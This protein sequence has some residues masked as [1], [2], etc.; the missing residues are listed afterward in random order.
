MAD[1]R[2][3]VEIKPYQGRRRH[4]R[5]G[6]ASK[7][8]I[9]WVLLLVLILALSHWL[10]R[11]PVS[12]VDSEVPESAE[13]P[14]ASAVGSAGKG[15]IGEGVDEGD[16]DQCH[17]LLERF[18]VAESSADRL[19]LVLPTEALAE[20]MERFY[21]DNEALRVEVKTLELTAST[22]LD[23]PEG[24]TLLTR[25][26]SGD[27]ATFDAAFRRAGGQWR[28]DWEHFVRYSEMSWA[29]FHSGSGP[30]R[31]VFRLLARQR[32][33]SSEDPDNSI[34]VVLSGPVRRQLQMAGYSASVVGIPLSE[35]DGQLL[36][37]A[38]EMAEAG[39]PPFGARYRNL[40]P[41]GMIR[42]RVEVGRE[43]EDGITRCRILRVL[44]CHW[45]SSTASLVE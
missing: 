8:V 24:M 45:L 7:L 29:R 10:M 28:L 36:Q 20:K 23:L 30:D 42:V 31:A 26:E 5:L 3:G 37:K 18:L 4:R 44:A 25:W 38:F 12:P 33:A 22:L 35:A 27:A 34:G 11:G 16:L 21:A 1:Q 2:A 14:S 39:E 43:K 6:L 40:N 15:P 13:M 41:E 17:E 9:G 19:P 32:S